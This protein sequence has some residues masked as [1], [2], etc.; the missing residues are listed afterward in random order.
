IEEEIIQPKLHDG[1]I[2]ELGRYTFVYDA[3]EH[4]NQQDSKS[5]IGIGSSKMREAFNGEQIQKN[6]ASKGVDFYNLGLAS[7]RPYFRTIQIEPIIES[8]PEILVIEIGPNSFSRL[9][10]PLSQVS[11]DRMN[12]LL[13]D[14]PLSSGEEYQNILDEEDKI[15]LHLDLK[16]RISNRNVASFEAFE[17]NIETYFNEE[18]EGWDCD[19]KFDDVRCV[20]SPESELFQTYVKYPPQFYNAI[21]YFRSLNDGS[22]ENFYGERLDNYLLKSYHQPEGYYNKNHRA[23]DF[24]IN[25]TIESDID[26]LLVGIPYNP[27]LK[28]RLQPDAWQYYNE[29]VEA[30]SQREELHI[31]DL[32]WDPLL[33]SEHYFNDFSHLSREG[34]NQFSRIITPI[35]DEI[36]VQR[37]IDLLPNFEY[38]SIQNSSIFEYSDIQDSSNPIISWNLSS[39][40]PTILNLSQPNKITSGHSEWLGSSWKIVEN[41]TDSTIIRSTPNNNIS[42]NEIFGSPRIDYC[43]V[44]KEADEYFIWLEMDPPDGNSDSVFLGKDGEILSFGRRGIQSFQSDG[45]ILWRHVGDDGERLSVILTEGIHCLNIWVREDGIG[46]HSVLFVVDEEF[47]PVG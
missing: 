41:E 22:I 28:E 25:Q 6:S 38:P 13:Y 45:G 24:I 30:Y 39:S 11:L 3:L 37:G 17:L 31:I 27:T 43:F 35:L 29:S 33:S 47:S 44:V 21:E 4:I 20:P 12:A 19:T 40:H 14:R 23:L 5:V 18:N 36:L 32:M 7:D 26:I 42:S 9:N 46:I 16:D 1:S 15:N 34:E 10:S 2:V 8:K